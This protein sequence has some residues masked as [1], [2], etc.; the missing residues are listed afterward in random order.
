MNYNQNYYDKI[1][2]AFLI[3]HEIKTEST[4]DKRFG[5]DFP[6]E[7]CIHA[8]SMLTPQAY[9]SRLES[10]IIEKFNLRS[11]IYSK[12]AAYGHFGKD[13]EELLWEKVQE[14]Y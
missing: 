12:T 9:G 7:I 10:Y 13:D 5:F 4:L 14:I 8:L 3:N 1:E 2:N 6:F 11:P